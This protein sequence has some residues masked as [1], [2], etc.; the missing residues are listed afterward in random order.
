LSLS[1]TDCEARFARLNFANL[2]E[3]SYGTETF[4][5]Q[6]KYVVKSFGKKNKK[7]R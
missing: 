7:V 4:M 6:I 1:Q 2:E 5:Q 3:L